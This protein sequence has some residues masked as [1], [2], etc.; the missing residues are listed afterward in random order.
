[1]TKNKLFETKSLCPDCF[2]VIEACYK[3]ING[4]VYLYKTCP[5]H[6]SFQTLFWADS[7]LFQ[8]WTA[9]SIHADPFISGLKSEKG[10]PF[11]C[12]L[13]ERHEGGV[14]TAVLEVTYRCNLA[15]NICFADTKKAKFDPSLNEI[16]AMYETAQKYGDNCS[17]QISGGE[18]TVRDDL[19]N[20][21]R[22]GKQMGFSHIQVNTNGLRLAAES[23]YAQKLKN[24]GADLIYLQFDGI[25]DG[26]YERI[27]GKKLFS[28][29]K[30]A[31]KNCKD[32]QLGVLLVPTVIP[33]VNLDHLGQIISFA[34]EN[35]PVVKG[36][37]F[38]PVSYFGRFDS[39][40]PT[41]EERC[42]ISDVMHELE[43]QTNGEMKLKHF[44]PRKR[45]DA[46]CAFSSL[47]YLS[48]QGKL[49]AITEDV[50][51][52]A[53]SQRKDFEKKANAFTNAYW[54]IASDN[55]SEHN[56]SEEMGKFK[57]RLKNYTLTVSGM[58]FQDVW[59]IDIGRLK[60]CC[61]QVISNKGHAIPLCAFHVTNRTGKRLYENE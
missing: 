28:V 23:D 48:E 24:A 20:I 22:M 54:R 38:Q 11:D 39:Q 16:K 41:D 5:N 3:E 4:K 13:C 52:A 30:Q 7:A 1:M 25:N 33:H 29:K 8:K 45:Y 49:H 47:F 17:I 43:K 53:E 51:N 18:P 2:E 6:G 34:K 9:Q 35:M 15:C 37:H 50:Q 58:G 32:A 27:R 56:V 10:C 26:I 44:V 46:H 42:S 55:K 36:V 14:C 19:E 12:G 31:I 61:V 40:N 21:L 57:T 59:N 60:G